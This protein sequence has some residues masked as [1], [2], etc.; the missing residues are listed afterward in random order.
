[1]DLDVGRPLRGV[2]D[3]E[4]L[5]AYVVAANPNNETNWLEW[6]CGLDLTVADGRFSVA[7]HILGFANRD[8]DAARHHVGGL[9][10]L[11][12]GAEAGN[13]PGQAPIDP[14]DLVAG[15]RNY[16]DNQGPKWSPLWVSHG[17][18]EVLVITIE[19]PEWGDDIHTLQHGYQGFHAGWVF[20]RHPGRTDPASPQDMRML[21][22]RLSRRPPQPVELRLLPPEEPI[23]RLDTSPEQVEAWL[24]LER[25]RLLAPLQAEEMRRLAAEQR[26]RLGAAV[27]FIGIPGLLGATQRMVETMGGLPGLGRRVEEDRS[28]DEYR[29]EIEEYLG[30]A[31][32]ALVPATVRRF[33]TSDCCMFV[34][35]GQNP[36]DR[37]LPGLRVELSFEEGVI[38][39]TGIDID[40]EAELPVSPRAWGPRTEGGLFPFHLPDFGHVPGLAGMLSTPHFA[41]PRV[42]GQTVIYSVGHLRPGQRFDEDS[43]PLL[44]TKADADE[45]IAHW[46]ATST[47]I[48]GVA[49]GE[50]RIPLAPAE[51]LESY[52]PPG[53]T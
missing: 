50:L 25:G 11:V 29:R 35:R 38:P 30:E 21:S 46:S 26:G 19:A 6:K 10:Y 49:I 12:L 41:A 7:K 40:I 18:A 16:V 8:P 34:L 28:P 44:V 27:N 22:A 15:I 9:G 4:D 47:D 52:L 33:L 5:V 36:T 14:A 20:V 32:P 31:R 42:E 39:M 1:L 24:E 23:C 43:V 51:R 13:V 17:G 45:T 2:G 53:S 3:L 48:D 37:N